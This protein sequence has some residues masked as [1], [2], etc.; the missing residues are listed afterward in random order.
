MWGQLLKS[1]SLEDKEKELGL[2]LIDSPNL[3]ITM[4][5]APIYLTSV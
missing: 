1:V 4:Q 2:R 5:I 3:A